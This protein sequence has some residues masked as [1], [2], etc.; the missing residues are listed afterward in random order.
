METGAGEPQF[1][2]PIVTSAGTLSKSNRLASSG[3]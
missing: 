2:I 3:A 1:V